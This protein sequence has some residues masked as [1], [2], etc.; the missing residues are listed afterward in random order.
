MITGRRH[1]KFCS[2]CLEERNRIHNRQ[3]YH[4]AKK[5]K[6]TYHTKYAHE[7]QDVT[8]YQR[9]YR[10]EH[11]KSINIRGK[12]PWQDV[13]KQAVSVTNLQQ[14]GTDKFLR[15]LQRIIGGEL[16]LAGTK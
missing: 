5:G 8:E 15:T 3:N 2:D 16:N 11:F 13:P 14:L 4:L 1:R 9:R 6:A 7:K 12:I 10:L